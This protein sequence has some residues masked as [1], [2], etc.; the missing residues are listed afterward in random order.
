MRGL[1]LCLCL[2]VASEVRVY[3]DS[4]RGTKTNGDKV[5]KDRQIHK[6]GTH[7]KPKLHYT[8]TA[9]HEETKYGVDLPSFAFEYSEYFSGAV[10]ERS[11]DKDL[12]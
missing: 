3:A 11:H 6:K 10:I 9:A 7:S 4:E 1:W 5:G 12:I 2:L 8:T